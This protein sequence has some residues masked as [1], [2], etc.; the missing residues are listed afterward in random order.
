MSKV[1]VRKRG[2]V[3]QYRFE[4]ASQE[5]KRKY[6]SKS[7]FKTKPEISYSDYLDYWMQEYCFINLKHRTETY[8]YIIKSLDD[9]VTILHYVIKSVKSR[10]F[11]DKNGK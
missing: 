5:E 8:K 10:D 2:D 11:R 4:I 7:G 1:S 9:V 3:F 6:I